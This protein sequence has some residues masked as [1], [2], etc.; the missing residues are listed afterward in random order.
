[1]DTNIYWATHHAQPMDTNTGLPTMQ[2]MVL[3]YPPCNP[4]YWATLPCNPWYWA[5]LPCN[6]W[7]WATLPYNPCMVHADHVRVYFT[8]VIEYSSHCKLHRL[9]TNME[10]WLKTQQRIN[11]LY[12]IQHMTI[13]IC[14]HSNNHTHGQLLFM[15]TSVM[16]LSG[17][18]LL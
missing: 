18:D 13:C 2:P 11:T 1:M 17:G 14:T 7:Y 6:P 8:L 4:W 16:I 3:G 5:T 12:T 15:A 9:L 10:Q